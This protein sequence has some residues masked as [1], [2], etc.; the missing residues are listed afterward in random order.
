MMTWAFVGRVVVK[1]AVLFGVVNLIYGLTNPL[2]TFQKISVYN[3]LIEGRPRLPYSENP[4]ES[5]NV[6]ILRRE[7]MFAAH[8]LS[9]TKKADDEYRVFILGDSSVW[10]W[11][12]DDDETYSACLNRANLQTVDGKNIRFYNLGYP[13][14]DVTKDLLILE[15]GLKY[16]PD[17]VVW[18]VTMASL[19]PHEQLM[20]DIVRAHP[21]ET[22]ALIE[23]YTLALN[24]NELPEES[25]FLDRTLVGERKPL[26]DWLRFQFYGLG[27][28]ATDIDF[29]NP[30]FYHPVQVNLNE[31]SEMITGMKD[32]RTKQEWQHEDFS[33]DVMEAGIEMVENAGGEVFV[34]N[35]PMFVSNGVNSENR[36]NFYYPRWAYDSY[37]S[38]IAQVAADENWYYVDF[39]D[40][41][42]NEAYT[43][44]SFHAN[45]QATCDF[46]LKIGAEVQNIANNST[47]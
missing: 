41:I 36:Y 16:A 3:T 24:A 44:S 43:D 31:G 39:W 14:L 2:H 25:D 27:W 19:Y 26:A 38:L 20:H 35:Q 28:A 33:F 10:G 6:T 23:K 46:A 13:I 11:L 7:G 40:A 29:R 12:L 42:P 9:G 1:A 4:S 22:R 5:Y 34:F 47:P 21:E 45:P 37:H 30:E 15:Y 32:G 17:M 18:P 8:E